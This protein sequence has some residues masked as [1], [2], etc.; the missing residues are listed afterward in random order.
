MSA[1]HNSVKKFQ[2]LIEKTD[3]LKKQNPLDLSSDQDL[4]IAIMH[5]ISIEEH[6]IFSG[7]K[8]ENNNF[9]DLV[10]EIRQM[11]KEMMQKIIKNS[12]GEL[13]CISKHL[14]GASMRL[15]EVGTKQQ[16]LGHNKEAYTLL[17]PII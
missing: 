16:S 17:I 14:L 13:W 2:D 8:L 6:F 15:L 5:L 7:A 11:R 10:T 9:Y 4:S 1:H 3:Q 12:K